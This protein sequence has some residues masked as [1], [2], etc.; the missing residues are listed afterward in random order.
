MNVVTLIGRTTAEID[1]RQTTSGKTVGNFTLAVNRLKKEDGA[2]FI[3]CEVWGRTAENM[4]KYVSK[5][6]KVGVKGRIRTGSYQDRNGDTKYTTDVVA[7][8][9]EF[10]EPPKEPKQQNNAHEEY[11]QESFVPE[12]FMPWE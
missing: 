7:E 1:L 3:R 4:K 12:G 11:S 6:N 10:L 5:G 9:V 2:D 8:H